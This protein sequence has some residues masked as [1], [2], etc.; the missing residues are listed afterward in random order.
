MINKS[1][2]VLFY[3]TLLFLLFAGTSSSSQSANESAAMRATIAILDTGVDFSHHQL[4]GVEFRNPFELE[5]GR[6]DDANGFIDD[7]SGW[8]FITMEPEGYPYSVYPAFEED[9]YR[10][11]EIRRK[12]SLDL[13][14][15]E[16]EK[17]YQ[18][19]RRDDAFQE[20]RRLFRRSIHGTHVAGLASGH[21]LLQI[22][23]TTTLPRIFE[24]PNL[25][26]ITYLGDA[27]SGPAAEPEFQPLSKGSDQQKLNHLEKFMEHYLDW[28][29]TKLG[30][31]VDYA[32]NFAHIIN[33][34]FGISYKS[35]GNMV[36]EWWLL[37]FPHLPKKYN[38]KSIKKDTRLQKLQDYFRAGLLTL[39]K[40]IVDSYPDQLFVFSAG[41]GN[42][43]TMI[44]SHYPSG[45]KC[46]RCLSVG[47]S[48]GTLEK[49]SFSNYGKDSVSLFAPGVAMES[50]IPVDRT[51]PVN[52]TSQAAPQV[53]FVAANILS[54]AWA[55]GL[56]L[57]LE[58]VKNIVLE[59]VDKKNFLTELCTAGGILN[60]QRALKMTSLLGKL[61]WQQAKREAYREVANQVFDPRDSRVK[62]RPSRAELEA[63]ELLSP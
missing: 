28:Q 24:R 34:S 50:S 16:E 22:L 23:G 12:R 58:S 3:T 49:A 29:A 6:D 25:L 31:A 7:V 8:N 56:Y 26:N 18:E 14:S 39:T 30:R 40:V 61:T 37:Q 41:N 63:D 42:D 27:N 38:E 55:R 4:S 17:W 57:N 60:P 51:L 46:S 35:A 10:Y 48:L 20:I 21:G 11:Y 19:K 33:A 36:E 1:K 43:P 2:T 52:G 5:N 9:F 15:K 62:S 54:T 13:A 44:E 59:T 45:V 32:S 53:S 47:A